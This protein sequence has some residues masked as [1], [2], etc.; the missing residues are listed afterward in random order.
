MARHVQSHQSHASTSS[1]GNLTKQ[2]SLAFVVAKHLVNVS[3][4]SFLV[5]HLSGPQ[6][7]SD[8]ANTIGVA[9]GCNLAERGGERGYPCRERAALVCLSR[10][11][12]EA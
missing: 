11:A 6:P 4:V 7:A 1:T 12:V 10:R 8:R 2:R 9:C 3:G 5:E